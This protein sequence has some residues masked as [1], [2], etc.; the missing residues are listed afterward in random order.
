[1]YLGFWIVIFSQA[2]DIFF[3]FMKVNNQYTY[4]ILGKKKTLRTQT[5]ILFSTFRRVFNK[6]HEI[7]NT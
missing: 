1:M 6:L 4:N 3:L 2:S 7:L 5:T